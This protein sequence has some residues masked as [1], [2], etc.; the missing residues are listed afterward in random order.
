MAVI[1]SHDF[2][3]VPAGTPLTAASPAV[4]G[5]WSG[6]WVADPSAT[7]TAWVGD[8]QGISVAGS[9]AGSVMGAA[10]VQFSTASGSSITTS[11]VIAAPRDPD[12][13]SFG[14]AFAISV[15]DSA[16]G[17]SVYVTLSGAPDDYTVLVG[18]DDGSGALPQTIDAGGTAI[19]FPTVITLGID[20]STGQVVVSFDDSPLVV[21]PSFADVLQG[22]EGLT[23]T[24]V[25]E[26]DE[27]AGNRSMRL[28]SA[29]ISTSDGAP[30]DPDPE[31]GYSIRVFDDFASP[32]GAWTSV[33]APYPPDWDALLP[34]PRRFAYRTPP[35]Q[36][37]IS[38]LRWAAILKNGAADTLSNVGGALEF[39]PFVPATDGGDIVIALTPN[40]VQP[41]DNWGLPLAPPVGTAPI[42]TS[43]GSALGAQ[44][45]ASVSVRAPGAIGLS[46]GLDDPKGV[47]LIFTDLSVVV[48]TRPGGILSVAGIDIPH[49]GW[50]IDRMTVTRGGQVLL[51]R[52]GST[53]T[54]SVPLGVSVGDLIGVLISS[55]FEKLTITEF[56]LRFDGALP[57]QFWTGFVGTY[58]VI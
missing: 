26:A 23:V 57:K 56:E 51:G 32:A 55:T 28:A 49:P 38:G 16:G 6:A 50:A 27:G 53:Q 34:K 46:A 35:V 20:R 39:Q 45:W 47:T 22:V 13:P 9:A 33:P 4:G 11:F 24:F 41:P 15:A 31:P 40:T 29:L 37:G 52:A 8:G 1:V 21:A 54:I 17:A 30:P 5:P 48:R 7:T 43:L 42:V 12:V 18:A 19:V 44:T 14:T 58:E 10:S 25:A 36:E 2:T 3:T